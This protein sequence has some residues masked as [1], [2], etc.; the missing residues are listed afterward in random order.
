MTAPLT[1]CIITFNEADR[2][3][4][5]LQSLAFCDDILVVDSGSTDDTVYIA[6]SLGAKVIYRKFDGYRSQKQFAVENASSNWVICLDADEII[7]PQLSN[8]IEA[9]KAQNFGSATGYL[10]ACC[11]NYHGRYLRHGNAYPS[12]VLRLFDRRYAGWHGSREIHE[13]VVNRGLTMTLPGDLFH[14]SYRSF[15]HELSK[16]HSYARK[17]AQHRFDIG[18]KPSL[19]KMLISPT[20][21]F[22]RGF[23]LRLGFLDGWSSFIYHINNSVYA[24]HK[25]LFLRDLYELHNRQDSD[26]CR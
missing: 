18:K 15:D 23:L 8:S 9:V 16:L 19:T 11:T 13:H 17:M 24:F 1:A 7:S 4:A 6:E 14:F 2:I 10:F 25:E 20:W 21:I 5:C 3:A 22:L 26:Q 12:R